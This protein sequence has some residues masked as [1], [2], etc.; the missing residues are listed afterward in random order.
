[1]NSGWLRCVRTLRRESAIEGQ[2][3]SAVIRRSVRK[4]PCNCIGDFFGSA[5][6]TD[7]MN[8]RHLVERLFAA[9]YVLQHLGSYCTRTDSVDSNTISS[10]FDRGGLR[11][12]KDSVLAGLSFATILYVLIARASH[13]RNS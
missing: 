1:M 7:G 10:V 11:Q 13:T 6:A 4:Q 2:G 5:D 8:S 9:K 3:L 12:S